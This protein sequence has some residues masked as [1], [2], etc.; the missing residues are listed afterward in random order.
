MSLN[1]LPFNPFPPSSDQKGSGGGSYEL[2]AATAETLG[3][4]KVGDNLTVEEDGTLN[5]A[6]PY[7]L[8]IAADDTLGGVKV[9]SGL[10]IDSETGE[11]SADS[12]LVDYST[13]EQA[14]G[15]KWIDGKDIYAITVNCGALPNNTTKAV[16]TGITPDTVISVRGVAFDNNYL[17]P[18]PYFAEINVYFNRTDN[19][20]YFVTQ[21]DM[22]NYTNCYMIIEYTKAAS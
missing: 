17:L 22:S 11:L 20:V 13:T 6:D 4:I 8:P 21:K 1:T 2:P 12:Q 5:A 18:M 16:E 7:T 9:G 15:Q 3:G 10:S 19:K 14:T